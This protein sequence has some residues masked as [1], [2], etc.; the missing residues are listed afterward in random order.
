MADTNSAEKERLKIR[1]LANKQ[2]A[3]EINMQQDMLSNLQASRKLEEEILELK[4]EYNE[5]IRDIGKAVLAGNVNEKKKLLNIEKEKKLQLDIAKTLLKINDSEKKILEYRKQHGSELEKLQEAEKKFNKELEKARKNASALTK[6]FTAITDKIRNLPVVGNLLEPVLDQI[7]SKIS[8][9]GARLTSKL[10]DKNSLSKSAKELIN[11]SKKIED[12]VGKTSLTTGVEESLKSAKNLS[13]PLTSAASSSA[14][15]STSLGRA[16]SAAGGLLGSIGGMALGI[17]AVVAAVGILVKKINDVR[18]A[19]IDIARKQSLSGKEAAMFAM[20]MQAA[21]QAAY[22]Y[23]AAVGGATEEMDKAQEVFS[24]LFEVNNK[25]KDVNIAMSAY[26]QKNM[27]LTA[28][29]ANDFLRATA[30]SGME[31]DR[32]VLLIDDLTKAFNKVTNAGIR[33]RDVVKAI[34][35]LSAT[36]LANYRSMPEVLAK[37]VLYLK[38]FG[39]SFE[40]AERSSAALLDIESSINAEM[41]ARVLTGKNLNLDQA[42]YLALTGDTAGALKSMVEQIGT[43]EE[44]ESMLPL[45][46]AKLAESIGMT[47][48]QLLNSIKHQKVLNAL[49]DEQMK[50]L[51]DMSIIEL[52]AA[53]ARAKGADKAAISSILAD[54]SSVKASELTSTAMAKM[55]IWLDQQLGVVSKATLEEEKA[56][57][58]ETPIEAKDALIRPGRAP[59]LFDKGDLIIAGTNLESRSSSNNADGT[60]L[61]SKSNNNNNLNSDVVSLL[62][63]LIQKIDQPVQIAIGGRV[64]D[65]IDT[66]TGLRRSYTTKVDSGYGVFG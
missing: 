33:T 43:Y 11:Q 21:K 8:D 22:E 3:D 34:G 49:T 39:L 17:G 4:K 46:R 42:R 57:V 47:S 16:S 36:T 1:E 10:F 44:I 45:Q 29:E 30:L 55:S 28:E 26:L 9:I 23:G 14:E 27:T 38:Q 24:E 31:M 62:K 64:I 56:A 65:E 59:V 60:N 66:R 52:R 53:E 12:V 32:N 25:L 13:A 58:Y 35:K 15:M 54:K 7:D 48:D 41:E 61:E 37:G 20:R 19:S 6:P 63:V 18:D 50:T 5:T 2:Q 40:D 51:S